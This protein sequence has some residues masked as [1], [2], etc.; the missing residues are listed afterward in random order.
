[1]EQ[2]QI[3]VPE[4]TSA[5]ERVGLRRFALDLL[6]TLV[7]AVVLFLGINAVSARVRVDGTSMLPTL[8]DGEFVLVNRLAYR[9]GEIQRGDI[10]VF[11]YPQ[12]PEEELIKRVVGLP[13]DEIQISQGEV[14]INGGRLEELYVA[15]APDYSGTWTVPAGSLFVLGDNRNNSSDSHQ[16][17]MLPT[18][19]VIG[20][21]LLIYWPPPMWAVIQHTS[22]H[23]SVLQASRP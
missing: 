3:E 12:R 6:E 17:G 21:A 20:R 5:E 4:S 14:S 10:I 13:H 2:T 7:L 18:E 23:A 9:L 1:L 15:A 16:W 19:N 11:H 22:N 8:Q